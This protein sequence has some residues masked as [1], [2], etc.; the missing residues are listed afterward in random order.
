LKAIANE[1]SVPD[2]AVMA[3]DAG[4]DGVLICSADHAAQSAALEALVYAVEGDRLALPRVDDALKRQ[5]RAK[6][7]FLTETVRSRPLSGKALS[8]W[9]GRGEHQ[10]IAD[11][12]AQFL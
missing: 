4:C 8:E 7:R 1:Y 6:E 3:I 5:R 11:E 9:L 12:M 2:A 10:A